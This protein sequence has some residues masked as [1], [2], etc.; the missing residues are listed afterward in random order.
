MADELYSFRETLKKVVKVLPPRSA[1]LLKL[2]FGLFSNASPLTLEAIGK[3]E[4]ITRERVRQIENDCL[5]KMRAHAD[6]T[7]LD[8]FLQRL[9]AFF[10]ENGGAVKEARITGSV[11]GV[12]LGA[13][14]GTN[15]ALFLL[16]LSRLAN[17]Y[18]DDE[19]FYARWC[20]PTIKEDILGQALS[21]FALT[22][23]NESGV[24]LHDAFLGKLKRHLA[25][26]GISTENKNALLSYAGLSKYLDKNSWGEWG[27]IASPLIKPK[28]MKDA[29]YAVLLKS[30]APLHFRAIAEHIKKMYARPINAQTVH[31][32]LI[33]D[34][35]FVLVGRGLYA[36]GAWGYQAGFVKDIICSI[37][38]EKA[39]RKEEIIEK[40]LSQRTVKE[41]T[42]L[43]NLQNKNH[44]RL[45]PDGT[46]TLVS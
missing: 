23:K 46:Y 34:S 12:P 16:K 37:L 32:E 27:H 17:R 31:N 3:R 43:M 42:V 19:N 11:F 5:K 6:I 36:L 40:V 13:N 9:R 35:R 4:S 39:C 41:S 24:L 26:F 10:E 7:L 28:G 44:F 1:N 29:S 2:R 21:A 20:L 15:A 8:P 14:E 25:S 30:G 33:K 18:K 38:K 45:R 22:L